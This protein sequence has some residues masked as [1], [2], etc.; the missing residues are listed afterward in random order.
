MLYLKS[1]CVGLLVASCGAF[2]YLGR[3]LVVGLRTSRD[4]GIDIRT[5]RS[6]I[7]VSLVALLFMIGFLFEFRRLK[8]GF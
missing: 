3:M 2:L 7:F 1:S 5:F 8:G 6:P 4:V